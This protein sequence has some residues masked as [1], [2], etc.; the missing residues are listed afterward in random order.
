[1]NQVLLTPPVP[2][3]HLNRHPYG[4]E[5]YRDRRRKLKM[6]KR[7]R[8]VEAGPVTVHR[9]KPKSAGERKFPWHLM[10]Y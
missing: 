6:W 2:S 4:T 9:G 8:Q 10:G 3:G 7:D 1:M 5:I